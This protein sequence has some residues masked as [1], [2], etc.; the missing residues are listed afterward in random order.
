MAG[1]DQPWVWKTCST[2]KQ[3]GQEE[4]IGRRSSWATEG[5]ESAKPGPQYSPMQPLKHAIHPLPGQFHV[6]ALQEEVLCP[7]V[8][9]G[10]TSRSRSRTGFQPSSA[11]SRSPSKSKLQTGPKCSRYEQFYWIRTPVV[12]VMHMQSEGIFNIRAPWLSSMALPQTLSPLSV[13]NHLMNLN[14]YTGDKRL[15][16]NMHRTHKF[17][18]NFK[19]LHLQ[20]YSFDPLPVE[21]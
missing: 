6:S 1:R 5:D 14:N 16:H 21:C 17:H 8:P 13:L 9:A 19:Y 3:G 4:E 11:K 15:Q 12:N 2:G 20:C 10:T 18:F 7:T